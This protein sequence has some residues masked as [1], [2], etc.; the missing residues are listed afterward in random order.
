MMERNA[1][2]QKVLSWKVKKVSNED[3]RVIRPHK[4]IMVVNEYDTEVFN[5]R[6]MA[7]YKAQILNAAGKM[8][9]RK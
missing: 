9:E 5:N 4:F 8:R 7:E 1:I 3:Y 6:M 2:E